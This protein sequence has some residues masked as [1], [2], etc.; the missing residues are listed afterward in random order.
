MKAYI[1][2][3]AVMG[4]GIENTSTEPGLMEKGNIA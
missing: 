4:K 2:Q 1:G 3:P